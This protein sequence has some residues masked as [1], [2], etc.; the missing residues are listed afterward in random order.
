VA[1]HCTVCHKCLTPCPVDIDFGDVS[2]A[3]RD[4]LRKHGQEALQSRHRRVDVL[5]E[6]HQPATIKL[7]RK[8][9]IDWGYKAQR[10]ANRA[11]NTFAKAQ[12]SSAPPPPPA[13]RRSRSR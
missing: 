6:R 1:D 8:V 7:T 11:L 13:S 5:P 4:L 9:M 10:L 2:M 12:T 3:L